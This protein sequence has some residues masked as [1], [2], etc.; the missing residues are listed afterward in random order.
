SPGSPDPAPARARPTP[1]RRS[2]FGARRGPAHARHL[3]PQVGEERRARASF[4][5][6]VRLQLVDRLP[7]PGLVAQPLRPQLRVHPVVDLL[8]VHLRR[9]PRDELVVRPHQRLDPG[10]VSLLVE[11]PARDRL[12]PV[13]EAKLYE[14]RA[15]VLAGTAVEGELVRRRPE[16]AGRELVRRA[17]V[18]DLVLRD[19][20]ER[21]VLLESRR[22]AG[23]L[24]VAPADDELVVS[25]LE[26]RPHPLRLVHGPPSGAP[27]AS[28]RRRAGT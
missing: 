14:R 15:E 27:S 25:E 21:D 28:S 9:E 24:R 6:E 4:G 26:K 23:P 20:G 3:L 18:P 1:R 11:V 5:V 7:E 16:L 13:E 12:R 17:R 19:R 22:D 10:A 2:P 8:A